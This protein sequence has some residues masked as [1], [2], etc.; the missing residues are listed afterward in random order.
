MAEFGESAKV[1][2]VADW[3]IELFARADTSELF[4]NSKQ[5]TTGA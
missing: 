3:T 4:E 5:P 1:G 2:D